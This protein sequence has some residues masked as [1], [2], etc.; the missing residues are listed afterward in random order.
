MDPIFPWR[1]KALPTVAQTFQCPALIHAAIRNPK[2]KSLGKKLRKWAQKKV[3]IAL[4]ICDGF[5]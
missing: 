1:K 5:N 3:V 2:L 4:A